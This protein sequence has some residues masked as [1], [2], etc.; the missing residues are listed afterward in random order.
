MNDS[1]Q[2]LGSIST[3]F[4]EDKKRLIALLAKV[5][6]QLRGIQKMI[7]NGDECEA[8]VQQLAAA[9]GAL[10]KA[11]AQLIACALERKMESHQP[12]LPVCRDDLTEIVDL[13]SRYV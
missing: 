9:R 4:E 1:G 11:F 10:S 6:G 3:F 12:D 5:E 8:I 7:A 2:D 13:L